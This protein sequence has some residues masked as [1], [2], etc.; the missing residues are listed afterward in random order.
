MKCLV[1]SLILGVEFLH[2]NGLVLDF[3]QTPVQVHQATVGSCSITPMLET[4]VDAVDECA[5][6]DFWKASSV[7]LSECVGS[8]FSAIL[9]QYQDLF[10][11]KT[12]ATEVTCNFIPST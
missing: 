1:A 3:T 6:P 10:Q 9:E 8:E 4:P 11:T 7:E 2:E 5:V 12:G